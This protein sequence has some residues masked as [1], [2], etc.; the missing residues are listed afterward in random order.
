MIS[1]NAQTLVNECR[2]DIKA[3]PGATVMKIP[4]PT[5]PTGNVKMGT[6]LESGMMISAKARD[7]KNFVAMMQF[8]DWLFYSPAGKVF[9]KWG[10]KGTTYE[11][12]RR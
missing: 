10:I 12:K 8:V 3:I 9:A 2:A 1:C 7:S 6:R 5:G 4:T 11:R